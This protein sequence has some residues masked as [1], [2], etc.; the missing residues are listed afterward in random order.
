MS[1]RLRGP[2]KVTSRLTGLPARDVELFNAFGAFSDSTTR[3]GGE[4]KIA[5]PF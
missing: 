2:L 5:V 1:M 3:Y 4:F